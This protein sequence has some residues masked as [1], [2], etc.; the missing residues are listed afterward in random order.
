[1]HDAVSVVAVVTS[2]P[3]NCLANVGARLFTVN[4]DTSYNG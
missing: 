3:I 4:D 2:L 1:M